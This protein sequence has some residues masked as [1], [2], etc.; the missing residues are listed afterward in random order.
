MLFRSA[1]I[2]V[3]LPEVECDGE[4][5]TQV[6]LNIARNACQSTDSVTSPRVTLRSRVARQ[7][8]LSRRRYRMALEIAVIDDGPGIPADIR[9]RIFYPLFTTRNDG[10]GSGLGLSIAQTFVAQHYGAIEVDSEPGQTEFRVIL[11][12]DHPTD[13]DA[14]R[15]AA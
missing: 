12:F 6:L 3:S 8:V 7:V 15:H 2:E 14:N 11:P 10:T 4:Q 13:V 5:I 1:D 9:D